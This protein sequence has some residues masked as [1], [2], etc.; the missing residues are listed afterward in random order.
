MN[1]QRAEKA[2]LKIVEPLIQFMNWLGENAIKALDEND[3][4][5]FVIWESVIDKF[6]ECMSEMSVQL[7]N[8]VDDQ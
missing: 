1:E 2:T 5:T 6:N 3:D 8:A 7:S 4:K